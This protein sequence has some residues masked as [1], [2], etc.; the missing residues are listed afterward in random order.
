MTRTAVANFRP[1]EAARFRWSPA[2]GDAGRGCGCFIGNTTFGA[3]L[4]AGPV[5]R[6]EFDACVRFDASVCIAEVDGPRLQQLLAA[7]NQGPDTPFAQRRGEFCFAAGPADIEPG[8]TYRI[9]TTDWGAKN[10]ARYFGEPALTWREQ[11]GL[12]LKALVLER[13]GS[14]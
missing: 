5:T 3:G 9:A 11:A 2:F 10:T 13:A 12:K 1:P 4:P 7:A 8:K 6:V 14:P